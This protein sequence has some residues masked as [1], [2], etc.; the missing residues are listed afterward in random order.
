MSKNYEKEHELLRYLYQDTSLQ[1]VCNKIAQLLGAPVA[2]GD[3]FRNKIVLSQDTPSDDF[4]DQHNRLGSISKESRKHVLESL[5]FKL[6]DRQP[7][8]LQLSF[9]RKQRLAC[10][11]FHNGQL[12]AFLEAVDTGNAFAD[13]DQEFFQECCHVMGLVLQLNA[14]PYD[15]ALYRPYALLWNYFNESA[16]HR[17]NDDWRFCSELASVSCFQLFWTDATTQSKLF[18]NAANSFSFPFWALLLT[19]SIIYLA[20]A[21]TPNLCQKF[22]DLALDCGIVAGVSSV[23]SDFNELDQ[24][25][26]QAQCSWEYARKNKM[27]AGLAIYNTYKLQDLLSKAQKAFPLSAF[28]DDVLL[29]IRSHDLANQTE[30]EQTLRVFL[31][32]EQN[33]QKTAEVLFLHKNTILYRIGKLRDVFGIN[34]K[35]YRQLAQ[36]Y[37]SFLIAE[38]RD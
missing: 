16:Q 20:D 31:E 3:F 22:Q 25:R 1:G 27:G 9:M 33:I 5:F 34:F 15:K 26:Q 29:Q 8:I 7:H 12:S 17:Y 37:C 6:Q 18:F 36:L 35:D 13:L 21:S 24:A 10:G 32:N 2:V 19:D 28:C 23:F 14:F 30:Y 11:I 4:D 38:N